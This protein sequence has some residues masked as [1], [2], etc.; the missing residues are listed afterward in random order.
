VVDRDII[1]KV[2]INSKIRRWTA[3]FPNDGSVN[4]LAEENFKFIIHTINSY[5]QA[6]AFFEAAL[7]CPVIVSIDPK[8]K[9]IED[10]DAEFESQDQETKSRIR[11][12][13]GFLSASGMITGLW[14]MFYPRPV[15]LAICVGTALPILGLVFYASNEKMASFDEGQYSSIPSITIS[16]AMPS[17]ALT[18]VAL[19]GVDIIYNWKVWTTVISATVIVS[20]MVLLKT[21]KRNKEKFAIYLL[22]IFI[23]AYFYGAIVTTN[24]FYDYHEPTINYVETLDKK[25]SEGS[26]TSEY[27]LTIAG[28]NEK[29]SVKVSVSESTYNATEIG[30]KVQVDSYPG[31]WGLEWFI[32]VPARSL[33]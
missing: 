24:R 20:T 29:D 18:L 8:R 31:L 27:V 4:L 30:Q 1:S 23:F 15:H 10:I 13:S 3:W 9:R 25:H 2:E 32:L 22:P 7:D 21:R 11:R 6:Q 14:L 5:Q 12:I 16:I 26:N 19:I 33:N 28:W 17:L